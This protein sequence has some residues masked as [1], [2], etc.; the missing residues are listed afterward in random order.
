MALKL[1]NR[2]QEPSLKKVLVY[3]LDGSGKS[4]F[5]LN[6]CKEHNLNPVCIDIDDTNYTGCPIVELDYTNDSTLFDSIK[7]T[8]TEIGRSEFDT[9][10]LDGVTSLLEMLTSNARGM[11]AYSDR[12]KRWNKI[13]QKLLA[14]KRNL[15]FIGQAD[16]EVIYTPDH[17]SSKAVIKVNSMVNEKYYCYI[18]G[19]QYLHETKKLRKMDDSLEALEAAV[20]QEAKEAK[21]QQKP[22]PGFETADKIEPVDGDPVLENYAKSIATK[23]IMQGDKLTK[24]TMRAKCFELTQNGLIPPEY[25]EQLYAYI[26]E[27][28]SGDGK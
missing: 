10:I 19:D 15:I 28:C 22:K 7:N 26:D 13:L 12:S 16:M 3:G 17:Q 18:K 1:K 4:T 2:K 11:A 23:V 27:N 24:R 9:I 25:K 21:Q 14:S 6:Y 5:A 8:I 20:A